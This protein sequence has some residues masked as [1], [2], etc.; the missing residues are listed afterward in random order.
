VAALVLL[1]LLRT[2]KNLHCFFMDKR[3]NLNERISIK[4]FQDFYWL[5]NELTS[6]CREMGISGSGGKIEIAN[7]IKRFLATGENV[8]HVRV[9]SLSKFDWNTEKLNAETVITDN[10]KNT[11]NVRY[12]FK[13]TVGE[14]FKFNVQFM[15]WM[16]VSKG[17]TLADAAEKWREINNEMRNGEQSK[18]IA[19]Q[20]EYNA[21]IRDFLTDNPDRT[22]NE[23]IE[24]WKIKK[25]RRGDNVYRKSDLSEQ[26]KV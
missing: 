12:F 8:P 24:Y 26:S 7:R 13:N 10:Y 11:E 17:K 18:Q 9:S 3:P 2:V 14:K 15:D 19:P 5:K 16:K 1:G 21:Y 25:S 4:D 6:F 23:A 22:K 20:F